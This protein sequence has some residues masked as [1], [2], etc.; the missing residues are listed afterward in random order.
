MPDSFVQYESE[1][2]D[3]IYSGYNGSKSETIEFIEHLFHRSEKPNLGDKE[4]WPHQK[5]AIL[6]VIFSYE[7]EKDILGN[8]YLLKI[9]TG[10]GKS[11]IIASIIAWLK[12]AYKENFDRFL[13]ITPNLIVRDRLKD[14][15][16]RSQERDKTV[17][18]I[19][20]LTPD[21]DLNSRINATVL[22]SG[23]GPQGTITA[24]IIIT[25]IQEL[26]TSG[27]NTARNL[28][29]IKD[30]YPRIAI[31]CDEAHNS[32]ADEFTRVLS[33]LKDNT[34]LRVDTTATP[35]R[36]DNTYPD[37]KLIYSFDITAAM[38]APKP[39]I[40]NIIVFQPEA[41][42]V[43]ITY[44]NAITNEKK[45]ITEF[46]EKEWNE[47]ER[48]IKP[49]QWIMDPAPMKMLISISLNALQRKKID[50][51]GKYKPLLFVVTMGIEE[52]KRAQKFLEDEFNIRTLLVTEESSE[53]D[54]LEARRIG[55][56]DSPYDAVVSVF[57]LREGW[58][59]AEVSVIL[60]LR[61]ILSPVYGQQIIGRGLRK[62]NKKNPDPETLFVV[63]HPMMDHGWLWKLMNVSRIRQDLLPTDI[64]EEKDEELPPRFKFIQKLV[65]PEKFIRVKE[66]VANTDFQSKINEIRKRLSDEEVVSNWKDVLEQVKYGENDSVVITGVAL[67]SIKKKELGKKFGTEVI[68]P[69]SE[70][71]FQ[72][73]PESKITIEIFKGEVVSMAKSLIEENS[74]DMTA[75]SKLYD[76]IMDH[77]I[78]KFFQD[79]SISEVSE[80]DLALVYRLL[81][82]VRKTFTRGII[83]GILSEG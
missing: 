41:R 33:I 45:K 50:S 81:L 63:D 34:K 69:R 24:D 40:K 60:L 2:N 29:F 67:E 62:I 21:E 66:P 13:I 76:A 15:F 83:K 27:T 52:A 78:H 72:E 20:S 80:E 68:E 36:A 16:V 54:R 38:E 30:S 64:I 18:E 65:N 37:S 28:A 23:S 47:Y 55:S 10:G 46:D 42:I 3:W 31:F 49:F 14:E 51:N 7:I 8:K 71:L 82:D 48:R 4:L 5:E 56:K 6:R 73:Q 53:E 22:E 26:Y 57:M 75:T 1:F 11:L 58:D 70:S 43:E 79:R 74:L 9:V 44:T 17:F 19:W 39:I 77:I 35:E 25:N 59:V 61:K 12:Y 32:V